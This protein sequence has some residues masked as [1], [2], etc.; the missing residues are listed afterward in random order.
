MTYFVGPLL[1][2]F[3]AQ[4]TIQQSQP[5]IQQSPIVIGPSSAVARARKFGVAVP[6]S[7]GRYLGR[8]LDGMR[9]AARPLAIELEIVEYSYDLAREAA[10]TQSLLG[11]GLDGYL[12][13]PLQENDPVPGKFVAAAK[14]P[15]AAVRRPIEGAAVTVRPDLA[16]AGVIQANIAM[17][18]AKPRTTLLYLSGPP[19]LIEQDAVQAFVKKAR[20]NWFEVVVVTMEG[21]SPDEAA[22]SAAQALNSRPDAAV[23]AA[24]ADVWALGA[25][26]AA[27]RLKRSVQVIG[28]GN[29]AEAR[30]AI[31][32][33]RLAAT[34]DLRP[35]VQGYTAV[36]SLATVADRGVCDNGQ[37][38]PCPVQSVPPQAVL[39]SRE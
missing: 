7:H 29:S 21:L 16:A 12:L 18:L 26:A 20:A 27:E 4:P 24:A 36:R 35:D 5:T 11:E 15:T 32:Q 38:P 22:S 2:K 3:S 19:D 34:V 6:D 13:V 23:I 37:N 30:T 10:V 17:S 1:P 33:K 28:L 31:E 9:E 25:V 39:A 14:V 8:M